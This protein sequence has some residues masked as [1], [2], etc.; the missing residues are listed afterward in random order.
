MGIAASIALIG[1]RSRTATCGVTSRITRQTLQEDTIDTVVP[2]GARRIDIKTLSK[3]SSSRSIR[4][5]QECKSDTLIAVISRR[6]RAPTT[7]SAQ[8]TVACRSAR[9]VA[10]F[11]FHVCRVRVANARNEWCQCT[12]QSGST[13]KQELT[14][15]LDMSTRT[16]R[17]RADPYMRST[18][19][20]CLVNSTLDRIARG[21]ANRRWCPGRKP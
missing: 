7:F 6:A 18:P 5:L 17:H 14:I 2:R 3:C 9:W 4:G 19:M 10:W 12:I 21:R 20:R 11:A 8:T 13:M 1:I 16:L 15:H